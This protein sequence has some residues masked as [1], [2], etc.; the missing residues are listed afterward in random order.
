M[1]TSGPS[2]ARVAPGAAPTAQELVELFSSADIDAAARGVRAVVRYEDALAADNQLPAYA[3]RLPPAL[4][5]APPTSVAAVLE[6]LS[7]AEVRRVLL[8]SFRQVPAHTLRTIVAELSDRS[9]AGLLSALAW[10]QDGP[11]QAARLLRGAARSPAPALR[12]VD[13][14]LAPRLLGALPSDTAA[15][16]G[17]AA[18]R[19]GSSDWWEQ[20]LGAAVPA[21]LVVLLSAAAPAPAALCPAPDPR[22][23]AAALVARGEMA[24]VELLAVLEQGDLRWQRDLLRA[25][26]AAVAGR[27]L[28]VLLAQS[29]ERAGL[30][31]GSLV[32]FVLVG[33]GDR[34][35]R[36]AHALRA[37]PVLAAV[38]APARAALVAALDPRVSAVVGPPALHGHHQGNDYPTILGRGQR[39]RRREVAPGVDAVHVRETV[40]LA[41]RSEPLRV[42]LLELDL[43][44]VRVVVR[45]SPGARIPL[46]Q[47]A[48][49]VGAARRDSARPQELLFRELGL[50]R[51]SEQVRQEGAV[52]GI[53]GGFYFDY[54]H[55]LDALD[56]GLD[57]SEE[58]GLAYGDVV[59]WFV[60]D[61]QELSPPLFGRAALAVTRDG[62]AHLRRVR[63]TAVRIDGVHLEWRQLNALGPGVTRYDR[64]FGGRAPQDPDRVDLVVEEGR[65][66]EIRRG[67]GAR[68]PL[69]GFV[70]SLPED[71]PL[72]RRVRQGAPVT[73]EHDFP[74]ALGPVEQAMACGPLLVRDGQVDLDV[75]AES[76][77]DKDSSVLPLSLTRAA[78]S[79]RAARS[80]LMLRAGRLVFGTVSG[81]MLGGGP[82]AISA[83]TTFGELAQM[84]AD[85]GA[86]D[87]MALDGGGSS[88][89]VAAAPHSRVVN[90]PTGGSDVPVGSERFLKTYLLALPRSA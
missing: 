37:I 82:P 11:V 77:G 90:V 63:M 57:L 20:V 84:C 56:L 70:L 54:G 49:R 45:S 62:A 86:D 4:L 87:A 32:D 3:D 81:T 9:L 53:N 89:L 2:T 46:P 66:V 16:V 52:A 78:D 27:L 58:V 31:L 24:S 35:S 79:F 38:P 5:A 10:G 26:P 18:R 88:T 59:D 13:P 47:V 55:Y 85:L 15:A 6:A 75:T 71:L 67:G 40:L 14:L 72:V 65:V 60:Q 50:V 44:R 33:E 21:E 42:D 23:A 68:I 34:P 25:L 12:L 69:L 43:A 29:A 80:F 48:A 39:R 17:A 73:V 51:L 7:A 41:G 1:T 19:D 74:A 83:G 28:A 36:R 22:D 8:G 64:L 61:G 30:L 76:F